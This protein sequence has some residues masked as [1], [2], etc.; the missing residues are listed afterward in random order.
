MKWVTWNS[1]DQ[2]IDHVH[3]NLFSATLKNK[4][5]LLLWFVEKNKEMKLNSQEAEVDLH[6]PPCQTLCAENDSDGSV[7]FC[8]VLFCS[9][10]LKDERLWPW[11]I[12]EI[13]VSHQKSKTEMILDF[14]AVLSLL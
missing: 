11:N 9:V 1:S 3:L 8:S 13:R 14:K 5:L 6:A 7:L 10:S 12:S 2:I 4:D